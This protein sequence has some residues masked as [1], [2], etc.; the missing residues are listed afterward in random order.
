VVAAADAIDSLIEGLPAE[1]PVNAAL[2]ERPPLLDRSIHR[3]SHLDDIE[4]VIG[5]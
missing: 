2:A 1:A 4:L 5:R 3:N